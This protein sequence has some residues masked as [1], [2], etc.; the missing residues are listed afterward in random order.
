MI[1]AFAINNSLF[2]VGVMLVMGIIGFFMEKH[3]IPVAPAVL[4]IVLGPIDEENF[5]VSMIKMQWDFT[6]FFSRPISAI[7][8]VMAL[9]V[10]FFP[11]IIGFLQRGLQNAKPGAPNQEN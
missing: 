10:W 1:G 4:G 8:C 7:L 2:D 11:V 6:Q 3:D 9:L 5:M